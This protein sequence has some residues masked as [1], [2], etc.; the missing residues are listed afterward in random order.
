MG[1]T[2]AKYSPQPATNAKYPEGGGNTPP[3]SQ[4]HPSD[5]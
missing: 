4:C 3:H 5:L 1:Q 2:G